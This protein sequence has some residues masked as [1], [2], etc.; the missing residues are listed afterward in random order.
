VYRLTGR[1]ISHLQTQFE[2][3]SPAAQCRVFAL[4]WPRLELHAR[5]NHRVDSM[6]AA[7]WV[8]EVRGLLARYG[9]LSRTAMQ[10]V[11]YRE[12]LEYLG[13]LRDLP[14]TVEAVKARTRR[15]ARHQETWFRSLSE[16]RAVACRQVQTDREV[17][18]TIRQQGIE[19][20]EGS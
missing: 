18:E 7:G 20:R 17:A 4:S 16:C 8:D 3:G 13:G 11:G 1:P 2:E 15:F 5:I 9:T 12:L 14:A 6:F 10:A 19:M